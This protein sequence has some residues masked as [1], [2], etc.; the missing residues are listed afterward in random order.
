MELGRTARELLRMSSE[1]RPSECQ[2]VIDLLQSNLPEKTVKTDVDSA[3]WRQDLFIGAYLAHKGKV[4]AACKEAGVG[5]AEWRKWR[6]DPSFQDKLRFGRELWVGRLRELALEKAESGDSDMIKFLLERLSPEEFDKAYKA[7]MQQSQAVGDIMRRMTTL[8][9]K[10]EVIEIY[11]S[12]PI[13]QPVV[14]ERL[15][16]AGVTDEE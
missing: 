11:Q 15:A 16:L 5:Y 3:S 14:V 6:D 4:V 8:L 10:D 1:L 7:Q 2:T 12:D 13:A 9:S